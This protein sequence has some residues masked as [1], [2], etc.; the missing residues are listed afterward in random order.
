MNSLFQPTFGNRPEQYIGRDGVIEQFMAGLREP[1]GARNRCT[2]FLGQRG[3]GKT[4]LLLE[5]SKRLLEAGVI[6]A[7]RR[8]ELVFAVPYLA[9]HLR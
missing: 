2:L 4:A 7:P 9:E 3:M 5:L 1:V 8:G 6:E